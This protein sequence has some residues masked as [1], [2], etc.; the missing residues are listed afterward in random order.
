MNMIN[1]FRTVN[2]FTSIL[3]NLI[4]GR[5]KVLHSLFFVRKQEL[6]VGRFKT[7]IRSEKKQ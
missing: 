4:K 5:A 6:F 7:V 3:A 1:G 2:K